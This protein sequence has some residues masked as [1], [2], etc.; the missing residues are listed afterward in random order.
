MKKLLAFLCIC[1]QLVPLWGQAV[2]RI[3]NGVKVESG[4]VCVELEC[5][6]PSI[7]RVKKYPSGKIPE[8][9]SLSVV[10]RPQNSEHSEKLTA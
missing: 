1:M 4:T 10:K 7:I 6:S 5:F 2:S 3:S 9:H 8:K